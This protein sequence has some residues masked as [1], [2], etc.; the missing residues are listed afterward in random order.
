MQSQT[1]MFGAER[2][3]STSGSGQPVCFAL[4]GSV[5]LIVCLKRMAV[6]EQ[7][8]DGFEPGAHCDH[9]ECLVESGVH[10]RV[11]RRFETG[12]N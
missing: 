6:K 2:S 4:F 10:H 5:G 1:H 3:A 8:D 9:I 12:P 7:P 11:M